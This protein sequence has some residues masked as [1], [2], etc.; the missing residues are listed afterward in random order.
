MLVDPCR[1]YL[2]RLSSWREMRLGWR[3]KVAG[4]LKMSKNEKAR[5]REEVAAGFDLKCGVG[6][7]TPHSAPG[8]REEE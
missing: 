7:G 3:S 1:F 4:W 8:I 5:C 2:G 6:G